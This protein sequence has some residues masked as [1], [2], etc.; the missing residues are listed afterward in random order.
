MPDLAEQLDD[1]HHLRQTLRDVQRAI[2]NRW[3]I[4]EDVRQG[5]M[6]KLSQIALGNNN[7]VRANINAAK[8][9]I[10]AERQNQVDQMAA[11]NAGSDQHVHADAPAAPADVAAAM[12][13]SV[14]SVPDA[15]AG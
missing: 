8:A 6:L 12:D 13:A 15:A 7:D 3:P 2:R 14:P 1:P 9:I 5:L 10:Q 11:V 4:R